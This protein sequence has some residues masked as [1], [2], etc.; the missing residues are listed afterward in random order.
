VRN[1]IRSRELPPDTP[2]R[3]RRSLSPLGDFRELG[4]KLGGAFARQRFIL[5]P[6]RW[7]IVVYELD[8]EADVIV[9]LRVVDGRT[10]SSPTA[11]R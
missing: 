6:W 11:N 9:I 4:A 7:M 1:L 8:R 2:E 10:S 5:G 3:L